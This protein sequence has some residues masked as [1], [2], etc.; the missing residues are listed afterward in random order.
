MT[1]PRFK[2]ENEPQPQFVMAEHPPVEQP[3]LNFPKHSAL[4]KVDFAKSDTFGKGQMFVAFFGHMT[5]MTGK[6]P[7]EHGGHRVL[8]INP[9]TREFAAFFT[10]KEHGSG[11]SENA[12]GGHG[13][14]KGESMTAGPRRP[15]DVRFS[16]GGDA[17]YIADFGTMVVEDR[18]RPVPGT[19]VIWRVVSEAAKPAGPPV[20]LSVPR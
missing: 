9:A 5:P 6:A 15:M 4:T 8:R 2:P 10:K 14:G 17:L 19:G 3:W 13:G 12:T 20:G 7:E 11:H 18:P 1:D 16:P